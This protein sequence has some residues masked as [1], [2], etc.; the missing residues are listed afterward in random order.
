MK[1]IVLAAVFSIALPGAAFAGP[2]S[3]AV[4]FFYVPAVKFEAD[5]QS[6]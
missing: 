2:A 6:A 3:N 4:K 5:N 1:P